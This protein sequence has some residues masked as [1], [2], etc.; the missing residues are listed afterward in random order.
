MEYEINQVD[1][2]G[3]LSVRLK[4]RLPNGQQKYREMFVSADC[5]R[6]ECSSGAYLEAIKTQLQRQA[7]HEVREYVSNNSQAGNMAPSLLYN[8]DVWEE[9]ATSTNVI[10]NPMTTATLMNNYIATEDWGTGA[11]N[12]YVRYTWEAAGG[13]TGQTLVDG[14]G[15]NS[16]TAIGSKTKV[17]LKVGRRF[18]TIEKETNDQG[19]VVIEEADL[20]KAREQYYKDTQFQII[21]NRAERKAEDLLKMFVSEIDFRNYKKNGFFTVKQGNKIYRIWRDNHKWVDMWER[22]E[23]SGLMMPKNRLCTHTQTREIPLAD[24]VVSKLMLIKSNRIHEH[25][26][27]H[28]IDADMKPAEE[29]ELILV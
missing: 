11:G 19:E 14:H 5:A 2:L 26:N 8:T 25:A 29:R 24:E 28:G 15:V 22:D 7:E 10:T 1:S 13:A 3:A 18:L 23:K 16:W 12:A 21:T 27:F 6:G 4:Y 20:V 17:K 9:A